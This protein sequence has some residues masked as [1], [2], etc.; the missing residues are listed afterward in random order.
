LKDILKKRIKNLFEVCIENDIQALILGA[1]GCGAFRN[2]PDIVAS[3]FSEELLERRYS[4]AFEDVIF[5]V[6]RTG[7]FC[8]NIAAFEITFSIFPP[9]CKYVFRPESN[10]RLF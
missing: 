3:A 10:K 6:K 8:A 1:F 7:S 4:H 5:A 2:P 9:A